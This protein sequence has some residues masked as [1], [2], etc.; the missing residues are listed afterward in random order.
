[1]YESLVALARYTQKFLYC[2]FG[3]VCVIAVLVHAQ[4]VLKV[5]L[6]VV[7]TK[8]E[9]IKEGLMESVAVFFVCWIFSYNLFHVDGNL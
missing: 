4:A 9:V 8:G 2:R 6:D 5:D 7:V 1:M 3:I